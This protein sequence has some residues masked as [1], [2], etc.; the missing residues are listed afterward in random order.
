MGSR[1][2]TTGSSRR[3][4]D[5]LVG[6]DRC[7]AAAGAGLEALEPRLLLEAFPGFP[8]LLGTPTPIALDVSGTVELAGSVE[9]G[10][11][12]DLYEFI[13]PG[14]SALTVDLMG[15]SGDIDPELWLYNDRGEPIRWN[16]NA[17][18]DTLDSRISYTLQPGRTYYLRAGARRLSSGDYRLRLRTTGLDDY[19]D[20][21]QDAHAIQLSRSG[22]GRVDG[23]ADLAGEA[24]F[25][26]FVASEAGTLYVDQY[27]P[28]GGDLRCELTAYDADGNVIADNQDSLAGTGRNTFS[29]RVESGQGYYLRVAGADG[30]TGA[31]RLNFTMNRPVAPEPQPAPTPEPDPSPPPPPPEPDP[32][33]PPPEPDPAPS[34]PPEPP[35]PPPPPPAPDPG[36]EIQPGARV[37]G[38]D[39]TTDGLRQLVVLGTD[40]DD[41]ITVSADGSGLTLLSSDGTSNFAGVFDR[42]VLY[43]FG[44]SDVLR[45]A[46]DVTVSDAIYG[47]DGDDTIFDAGSGAGDVRG[48]AGDDLIVSVGG[49]TDTVRGEDGLDSFWSDAVDLLADASAAEQAAESVHR[50]AEFYQPYTTV[51]SA[52]GYISKTLAGQDLPDPTFTSYARRYVSFAGRPLFADG[53]EYNDIAQGA[54]GDCYFLASLSSLAETDPQL[55]RQMI[56]PLGDGTYAVRF[57]DDGRETYVRLDADLPVNASGS[58]AY[59]GLGPDG[60]LWVPLMEKAY[61]YFR[62]GEN[63][64]SSLNGGWMSTVYRQLTTAPVGANSTAA[65]AGQLYSYLDSHL[66]AGH[67]LTLGSWY[68]SPAPIVGS[69]AYVVMSVFTDAA[70]QHA[71]VYNPWGV[72]GRGASGNYHDGLVTLTIDQVI[73]CFSA[74]VVSCV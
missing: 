21:L 1:G 30:A 54:V 4:R 23:R 61:A 28:D 26:R 43:G 67:A 60:E 55:V 11:S 38:Y 12:S 44:G 45:I 40:L 10:G 25:F 50:I 68:N 59:A 37:S 65:L 74:V 20:T 70:G 66:Q 5:A 24:D 32:T 14:S 19:G 58:P 31:Y 69:H 42:V 48:G 64:Y 17:D 16:N 27:C 63:S 7:P 29:I 56:A 72:D 33:P 35:A 49:G 51:P 46:Y 9:T 62:Y 22:R 36:L 57:Y 41:T 8:E 13:A 53:P 15:Q 52:G 34:P 18:R 73:D 6:H 71:V 2:A 47:G 3:R 39:V